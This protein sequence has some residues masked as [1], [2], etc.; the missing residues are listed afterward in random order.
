MKGFSNWGALV[1]S[2]SSYI[3]LGR[4]YLF[5]FICSRAFK[6]V[7]RQILKRINYRV[8][9]ETRDRT[10]KSH[11]PWRRKSQR[12]ESKSWQKCFDEITFRLLGSRYQIKVQIESHRHFIWD[13]QI[14]RI[15]SDGCL[16]SFFPFYRISSYYTTSTISMNWVSEWNS[17]AFLIYHDLHSIQQFQLKAFFNLLL[18]FFFNLSYNFFVMAKDLEEIHRNFKWL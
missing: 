4:F 9:Y 11:L 16:T 14:I 8:K 13:N 15:V 12:N 1:F 2:R 17:N 5:A 18:P 3:H 7:G 10:I 6:Y